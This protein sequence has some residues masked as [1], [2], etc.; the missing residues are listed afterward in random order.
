MGFVKH[1]AGDVLP[2]SEQETKIA[3]QNWTEEDREELSREN[4]A[5]E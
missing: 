4:E 5:S 3:S 1:G 2:E